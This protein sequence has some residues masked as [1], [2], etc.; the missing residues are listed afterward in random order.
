MQQKKF[1]T[2]TKFLCPF[3]RKCALMDSA[4]FPPQQRFGK[5]FVL[6]Y[7]L[8]IQIQ[9]LFCCGF[10]I[11][12]CFHFKYRQEY[13]E[14]NEFVRLWIEMEQAARFCSFLNHLQSDRAHPEYAV[15]KRNGRTA[16]YNPPIQQT[17]RKGKIS[18]SRD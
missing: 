1:V 8:F 15:L 9:L 16:A 5:Y 17:P 12:F 7:N 10:Y 18:L 11:L 6:T 13:A 14:Y 2:H 4:K 3:L